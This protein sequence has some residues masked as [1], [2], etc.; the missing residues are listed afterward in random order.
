MRTKEDWGSL[1]WCTG[2]PTVHRSPAPV[3]CTR[4]RVAKKGCWS[5]LFLFEP[6]TLTVVRIG[7]PHEILFEG[8]K[9]TS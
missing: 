4:K 6:E 7:F 5:M 8:R 2:F 3:R 9:T 1:V